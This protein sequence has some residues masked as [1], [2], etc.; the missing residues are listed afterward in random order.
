[1][2]TE[3]IIEFRNANRGKRTIDIIFDNNMIIHDGIPG[4]AVIWDDD[5]ER[6]ICIRENV[7][8]Q[9]NFPWE[10]FVSCYQHI[11]FMKI[12]ANIDNIKNYLD[13]IGYAKTNELLEYLIKQPVAN[14]SITGSTGD[15]I[16][17]SISDKKAEE[18]KVKVKESKE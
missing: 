2:K 11:Q 15:G 13:K 10:I 16:D 14:A 9:H 6:I 18:A 5:K 12:S 8:G 1:M 4:Q 7:Y 17:W 3:N